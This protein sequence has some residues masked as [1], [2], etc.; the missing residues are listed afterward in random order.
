[1]KAIVVIGALAVAALASPVGAEP[2]AAGAN[3]KPFVVVERPTHAEL[4]KKQAEQRAHKHNHDHD[5]AK[6][7]KP[8]VTVKK[9][10][11]VGSSTLLASGAHWTIVPKGSVIYL[12]PRLKGKV[13]SKPQGTLQD[14]PVFL[15]ENYGWIHLHPISLQ[16][17]Q[18]QKFLGEKPMK[19]YKSM[20]KAVIATCGGSPISVAPQAFVPPVD[21]AEK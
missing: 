9:R 20:G 15:R 11:L 4:A 17:A 1:M 12:P 10:S 13:V 5:A 6:P 8:L 3:L 19:A 7:I 16:H 21:N 14:W 2:G 18:G